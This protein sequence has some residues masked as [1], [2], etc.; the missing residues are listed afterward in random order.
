MPEKH[1][2]R[3]TR[4][5]PLTVGVD[6]G[7]TKVMAGVVDSAG[8]V[9]AVEQRP[10][11]GYDPVAVE[12]TIVDLVRGFT[13]HHDVAAVGIG[14]AGFVDSTRSVVM[15]APHLSWRREPLRAKVA[16]RLRLPVVVDN[17]ANTAALAECRF[18]AARGHRYVL[19]VTLGTGIGG[20]L[21][22]DNRVYRGANGMAGEFG[23]VQ[24]VPDGHRCECGNRG[25]W[26]Q[27]ASGNALLREA[28]ELVRAGSPMAQALADVVDG[29]A[30][31]LRGPQVT[32]A[33]RNGDPLSRELL[34]D[35][36][37]WLGVGLAGMTA[38]FDPHCIVV[39]GGLADAGDL[40]LDPARE[41]FGR[42]LTGRGHR[43]SPVIAAAVLG[44]R[45][46][47]VGAADMARSAARRSRRGRLR[48]GSPPRRRPLLRPER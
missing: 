38:A 11:E 14:A 35:V 24:V 13:A 43:E 22:I 31:A 48:R 23:H 21:V 7:G 30:D 41:A 20:A 44:P 6:I 18:G 45:A 25:C 42:T 28:R 19:C 27:Y 39:G 12:N 16:D 17:D 9:H 32:E 47:F 29:D 5:D 2:R 46:G 3:A 37:R 26:E 15:F 40:L 34:M 1:R 36:G 10:T 33:A 4:W 8:T